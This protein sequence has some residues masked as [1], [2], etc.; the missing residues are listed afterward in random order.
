MQPA[1]ELINYRRRLPGSSPVHA[2]VLEYL[3]CSKDPYIGDRSVTAHFAGKATCKGTCSK[4]A[5]EPEITPDM[6]PASL[7]SRKKGR[8]KEVSVLGLLSTHFFF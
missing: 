5:S 1:Q 7:L 2:S 4:S 8:Q 6:E 3:L